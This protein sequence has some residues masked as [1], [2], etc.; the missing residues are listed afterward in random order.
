MYASS[1]ASCFGFTYLKKNTCFSVLKFSV[2]SFGE[3]PCRDE[4]LVSGS[5]SAG[6]KSLLA[7][8]RPGEGRGLARPR[9]FQ[10]YYRLII[11]PGLAAGHPV[12]ATC[13]F[14]GHNSVRNL[15]LPLCGKL[16]WLPAPPPPSIPRGGRAADLCREGPPPPNKDAQGSCWSSG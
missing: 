6:R 4:P 13:R 8:I 2:C 9:A 10:C 14:L 16:H 11:Q 15:F 7:A 3:P 12:G 5:S 1:L